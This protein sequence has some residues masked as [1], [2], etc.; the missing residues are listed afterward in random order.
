MSYWWYVYVSS[1][2]VL[3][4]CSSPDEGTYTGVA[5]YVL[6]CLYHVDDGED[7]EDDAHDAYGGTDA[8]HEGEGEEVAPHGNASIADGGDDGDEEPEQDG[9]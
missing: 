9:G 1:V 2:C 6:G 4:P 5:P 8:C 3:L 7:G